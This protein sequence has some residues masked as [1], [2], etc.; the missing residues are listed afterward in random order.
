MLALWGKQKLRDWPRTETLHSP[1][2]GLIGTALYTLTDCPLT[3]TVLFITL[4]G[5]RVTPYWN[6]LFTVLAIRAIGPRNLIAEMW[7]EK[8]NQWLAPIIAA[9][10][11]PLCI[12]IRF[13]VYLFIAH[14]SHVLFRTE[15]HWFLILNL[16]GERGERETRLTYHTQT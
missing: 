10:F 15:D 4:W 16:R 14:A 2:G 12:Q 6:K 8:T 5:S 7:R 11:L 1:G 3:V 9:E 13:S